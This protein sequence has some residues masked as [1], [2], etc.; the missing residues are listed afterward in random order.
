MICDECSGGTSGPQ[1]LCGICSSA[2]AQEAFKNYTTGLSEGGGER[3]DEDE[4]ED[5]GN[6]GTGRD[7]AGTTAAN[8]SAPGEEATGTAGVD[9][10]SA[11]SNEEFFDANSDGGDEGGD[12]GVAGATSAR[13]E[14]STPPP[15]M[16]TVDASAA[17]ATQSAMS[18]SVIKS[19]IQNQASIA[20]RLSSSTSTPFSGNAATLAQM[21]AAEAKEEAAAART[22][23]VQ[24]AAYA[25]APQ[26]VATLI[27][28]RD[29]PI[30]CIAISPTPTTG[31]VAGAGA[32]VAG[33]LFATGGRDRIVCVWE[34]CP[35]RLHASSPTATPLTTTPLTTPTKNVHQKHRQTQQQN[36]IAELKGQC[37]ALTPPP[38]P[39]PT[40]FWGTRTVITVC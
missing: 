33:G 39:S 2:D 24:R 14:R 19:L 21:N 12:A 36:P 23:A 20:A 35:K 18:V 32:A 34:T 7:I 10:A 27:G 28:K 37:R 22:A 26:L 30:N 3:E 15:S 29:C 6:D 38:P 8:V 1:R 40:A 11:S 17:K 13:A 31:A 5:Q 9:C 4:A 16:P 25:S